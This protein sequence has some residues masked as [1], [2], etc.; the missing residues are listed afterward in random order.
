MRFLTLL[1]PII[2]ISTYEATLADDPRAYQV[3]GLKHIGP[4][5]SL[6]WSSD[7]RYLASGAIPQGYSPHDG[8]LAAWDF[9]KNERIVLE[10][11]LLA[12]RRVN[13]LQFRRD[14]PLLAAEYDFSGIWQFWNLMESQPDAAWQ[15]IKPVGEGG[16]GDY[17]YLARFEWSG[18]GSHYLIRV[19]NSD[20]EKI[21]F[22]KV[23]QTSNHRQV[24]SL[25]SISPSGRAGEASLSFDGK[26]I[27]VDWG[28]EGFKVY[29]TAT[30]KVLSTFQ[31]E[32]VASNKSYG[33]LKWVPGTDKLAIRSGESLWLIDT[34]TG[35]TLWVRRGQMVTLRSMDV[36]RDGQWIAAGG[37]DSTVLVRDIA[38]GRIRR[39]VKIEETTGRGTPNAILAV[40]FSPD[41]K[42][43][44]FGANDCG[45]YLWDHEKSQVGPYS[46]ETPAEPAKGVAQPKTTPRQPTPINP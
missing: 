15:F 45:V 3:L 43:V 8:E 39:S 24:F 17:K 1:V 26:K 46:D 23:F 37:D 40:A 20:Q 34:V 11:G 12:G 18:D 22:I 33:E 31:P 29:D 30:G 7:G 5:I 14:T 36:S 4:V 44:A 2:F 42:Q 27:V 19:E 16:K 9:T 6:A 32:P 35:K 13:G 25:D 38:T 10:D 21:G 28:K 41:G